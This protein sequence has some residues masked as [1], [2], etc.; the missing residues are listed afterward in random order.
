MS[1]RDAKFLLLIIIVILGAYAQLAFGVFSA[2]WDNLSAFFPYRYTASEW[3]NNGHLPLWDP[4][5][6]LGYPM[7]ANPQGAAWN[8]V[9]WLVSLFTTYTPY[10]MNLEVVFYL[11]LGGTGF[12]FLLKKLHIN[13]QISAICAMAYGLSGFA[14]GT[15][16]MVGFTAAAGIFPWCLFFLITLLLQPSFRNA[17]PLALITSFHL[18]SAYPAFS[19]ILT[20]I[21]LGTIIFYLR[22]RLK[23]EPKR[24][25]F[26]VTFT[27]LLTLVMVLILSGPFMY[28]VFDS[29]DYFSRADALLYEPKNFSN[30]FSWTSFKTF[31]T[32]Y[33]IL[34]KPGIPGCDVS[35]TNIFIGFI[36]LV[37]SA[38]GIWHYR[39]QNWVLILILLISFLLAL[40][41]YT[42]VHEFAF[43]YF[44]GFSHFRHPYLFTLY[45]TS[46]LL[47]FSGKGLE[48][49]LNQ[50][51]TNFKIH[52]TIIYTVVLAAI[53]FCLYHLNWKDF[54]LFIHH[55]STLSERSSS[56]NYSHAF[57]QLV[58]T[59]LTVT[60]FIVLI[61]KKITN[62]LWIPIVIDLF[63]AV[64]LNGP[65]NMYYNV[66]FAQINE[67]L[68]ELSNDKLTNQKATTSLLKLSTDSIDKYP[69]FWVNLNTFQRTTGINGYN[70]FIFNSFDRFSSTK[71]YLYEVDKGLVIAKNGTVSSLELNYN[72]IQF[73]NDIRQ[74]ITINQNFH[75]NWQCSRDGKKIQIKADHNGR[76]MIANSA[77]GVIKLEYKSRS[78]SILFILSLS[79]FSVI[80]LWYFILSLKNVM[81]K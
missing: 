6:N 12:Y 42:P 38:L 33:I 52:I 9:V 72:S 49:F 70:P 5:Q 8:P 27:L 60:S 23:I 47:L 34:S 65:L 25:P 3:I 64:Q 61:H 79:L 73:T 18:V 63:L 56:S 48:Y 57:I 11:I 24:Y 2:K 13:S 71:K 66:P 31:I 46:I 59:T 36:P 43:R 80:S 41:N 50:K 44:P 26:D 28:S 75:H 45:G 76:L 69:G 16:H 68:E 77:P 58:I 17:I 53:A 14:S 78:I 74:S 1:R 54:E 22:K 4:Y 55:I 32:P 20:Y 51:S 7:H 30:N 37:F 40:G 29:L 19:I 67:S 62:L 10:F 15:M 81:D 35:L 39:K 21:Y